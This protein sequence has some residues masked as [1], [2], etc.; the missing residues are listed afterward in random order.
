MTSMTSVHRALK[1]DG[2]QIA[3]LHPLGNDAGLLVVRE[4]RAGDAAVRERL[5]DA[6]FG[7][8]RFAKTSEI[9]R[10]GR[11]PAH[12]LAL[13]AMLNGEMVGTVRLWHVD[14]GGTPALLLGPLAV[15]GAHRAL[16]I[17]GLL[18]REAIARARSLGHEAILL[19]GD[20]PYYRKFGFE[21]GL[22]RALDLPGPV[23]HARFLALE[24]EGG[25]LEHAR[26]MVRATGAKAA[27][28]RAKLWQGR[29]AA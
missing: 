27:T 28:L 12:G 19:V 24:L 22:T 6:A 16:G 11:V 7:A 13:V 8:E 18:M 25:A 14:A 15:S 26:G 9:L 2:A 10:A 1:S 3:S 29:R 5:L 20:E 17:G 23:D 21:A 4:E